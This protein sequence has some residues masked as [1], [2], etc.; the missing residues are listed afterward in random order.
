LYELR[1]EL[2]KEFIKNIPIKITHEDEEEHAEADACCE[3]KKGLGACKNNKLNVRHHDHK[4]GDCIGACHADCNLRT[5]IR[6]VEIP[7]FFH[8]GKGYDNHFI[9]RPISRLEDT[10]NV[11]LSAIPDNNEKYK[12]VNFRGHRFLDIISFLNSGLATLSNNLIGDDPKNAPCFHKVFSLKGLSEDE[13]IR[14]TRKGVFP[15][16]WFDSVAKL[17]HTVLPSQ[18]DFS[19]TCQASSARMKN[20]PKLN[21][22]GSGSAARLS[23]TTTTCTWRP[24]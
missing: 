12:M 24:T 11:M 9:I 18:E 4:T 13:L 21:G 8:N 23:M 20:T 17:E 3:C 14:V 19:T 7:V 5:W 15:Y 16:K 22:C 6:K 10:E 2:S 1:P